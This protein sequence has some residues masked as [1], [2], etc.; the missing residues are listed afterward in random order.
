MGVYFMKYFKEFRKN[1]ILIKRISTILIIIDV[2]FIIFGKIGI[3]LT[4][5]IIDLLF[6][7]KFYRCPYCKNGLD[8]RQNFDKDQYCPHCGD[9]IEL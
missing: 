4:V 1:L 7:W 3:A 2:L 6:E 8:P 5:A 9:K